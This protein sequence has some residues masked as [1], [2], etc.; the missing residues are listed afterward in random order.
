[1][2]VWGTMIT[3]FLIGSFPTAYILVRFT[4]HKDI[5]QV[6][7]GNVGTMNVRGQLGLG[8]ALVVLLIDGAKGALAVWLCSWGQ[9]DPHL[10]L[11]LAVAGHI[12]PPWLGFRGGKG[13]ATALGGILALTEVYI[14]L[15][16]ALIWLPTYLWLF[17]KDV[18][19]A[20]MAGATGTILYALLAGPEWGLVLLLLMIANKH[21]QAVRAAG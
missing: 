19:K 18:D 16:F 6:G 1:M 13:L 8:P 12:Y 3:C 21:W 5:R 4:S 10:G 14:I 11:A 9:A 20:N 2:P 7:S 17:E 15:I